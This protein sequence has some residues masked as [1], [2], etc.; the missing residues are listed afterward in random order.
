MSRPKP[1]MSPGN[2]YRY[3]AS[4]DA[5]IAGMAERDRNQIA[6]DF[7]ALEPGKGPLL[8]QL[9]ALGRRIWSRSRARRR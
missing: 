7:A 8:D 1:G 6:A 5:I 9:E 3:F 4:K 2:L